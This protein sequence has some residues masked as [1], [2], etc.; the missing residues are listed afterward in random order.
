M[1]RDVSG[2]SFCLAGVPC[3]MKDRNS[4]KKQN[5]LHLGLLSCPIS[6]GFEVELSTCPPLFEVVFLGKGSDSGI[7]L[8][9]KH[10]LLNTGIAAEFP[11]YLDT[12]GEILTTLP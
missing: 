11:T 10:H 3:T 4:F 9:T 8:P 6:S 2:R 1:L 12:R 7:V 5:A